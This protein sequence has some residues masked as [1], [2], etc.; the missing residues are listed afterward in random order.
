MEIMRNKVTKQFVTQFH[1]FYCLVRS[2]S[3]KIFP[4]NIFLY[5]YFLYCMESDAK[6]WLVSLQSVTH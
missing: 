6:K 5:N 4:L 2:M 3:T 1:R